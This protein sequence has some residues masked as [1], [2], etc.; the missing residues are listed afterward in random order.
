[1]QFTVESSTLLHGLQ[2]VARVSPTR[3]TMPILNHILFTVKGNILSMRST[4]IEITYTLNLSIK[5]DEDGAVAL[6]VRLLQEITNELPDTELTFAW[7]DD[8]RITLSIAL[9]LIIEKVN[10]II[11]HLNANVV[12]CSCPPWYQRR[13]QI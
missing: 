13:H 10:E 11:N 4:D 12:Q 9:R 1:M 5:G 2:K 3:S 6:P 8:N 7:S